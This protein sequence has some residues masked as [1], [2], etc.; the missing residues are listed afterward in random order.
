M[1]KSNIDEWLDKHAELNRKAKFPILLDHQVR[2]LYR[3]TGSSGGRK[4]IEANYIQNEAQ[5][6]HLTTEWTDYLM[7]EGNLQRLRGA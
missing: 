3:A 6:G 7:R 5:W 4:A 2:E 1:V